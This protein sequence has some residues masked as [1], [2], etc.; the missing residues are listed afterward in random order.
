MMIKIYEP[1]SRINI[2]HRCVALFSALF[3]NDCLVLK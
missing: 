2:E 3:N 1:D